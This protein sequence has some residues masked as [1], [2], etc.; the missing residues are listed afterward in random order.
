MAKI[1]SCIVYA[2]K[3]TKKY[4]LQTLNEKEIEEFKIF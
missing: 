3:L 4:H 2:L 1:M